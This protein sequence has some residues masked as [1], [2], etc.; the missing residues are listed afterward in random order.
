MTAFEEL[1]SLTKG[2]FAGVVEKLA[3]LLTQTGRAFLLGAG[4][5]KVAGL[6]LTEE[7]TANVLGC[8]VLDEKSKQIL[9][10][11]RDRFSGAATADIED[12]LSELIDLLAIADRRKTK[13]AESSTLDLAGIS[14]DPSELRR[15][16]DQVKQAIA[17][18]LGRPAAVEVHRRFVNALHQPLRPGK[19]TSDQTVDY[20]VLNYDTV[21][22]DSL[23]LERIP[24][25][26]GMDGGATGWWNPRTFDREDLHAR[27]LKL[28]GSID[29]REI[30]SDP[31]PR[32]V[33]DTVKLG[34]AESEAQPILIWPAS[35]KY[36]ETQADPFAQIASRA[37]QILHPK[38]GSQRVLVISGYGFRDTHINRELDAALRQAGGD[39]TVAAFTSDDEPSGQ[40]KVWHNDLSVSEQLLIFANRGFFHG[41]Q[42]QRSSEDLL[43]W[44]FENFTRLIG[45]ER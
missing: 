41:R 20:L 8:D 32:R 44:K 38:K 15:A 23:A 29:W 7:L 31:L 1:T 17:H 21:L 10:R 18:V 33:S 14:F 35:T 2:P 12:Y 36:R 9:C 37:R 26:D 40:L 11:I 45:G 5:S 34:D 39:L 43:W 6:P 3:E 28:H 27:I 25:S 30:E 24:F 22:E 16:V 13:E 42:A 4:C 19:L